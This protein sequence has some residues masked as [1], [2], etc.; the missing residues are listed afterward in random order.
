VT[1]WSTLNA[2]LRYRRTAVGRHSVHSPFVFELLTKV[3]PPQKEDELDAHIAEEWRTECINNHQ[4]IRVT[5]FGTGRPGPRKI[6]SIARHAA[7]RPPQGQLLHRIVRY[8]EPENLLELGTSLGITTLYQATAAP[9]EK[10]ITL[11]GCPE[12]AAVA[13]Q[14]FLQ[15][16][17]NI[18]V[19]TGEFENT[20]LPAL[21]SLGKADYIFFDG[22]HRKVPTLHYFETALPFAHNNSLFIFDDIHWSNEMEEAWET[23]RSRPEVRLSIDLFHFGLV[24]F[25]EEQKE[26]EHF[27]LRF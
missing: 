22:N 24:F 18:E 8:F 26:K 13:Q 25:R 14:A 9:F 17:L 2:Y 4:L 3:F 16:R 23:I 6:S 1:A 19:R 21:Q 20:L 10:F 7:K 27:V 15:H 5:D 12:T 11:E